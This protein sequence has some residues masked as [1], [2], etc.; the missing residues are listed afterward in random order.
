[1]MK[2][3]LIEVLN[4]SW[5]TLVI[6]LSIVIILRVSYF[7][8]SDKK[9][10]LHEELFSLL[11]FA[12]ILAL[13][14]LVVEQD[15]YFGNGFNLRPFEEIFR[16]EIGSY[17]FYRQ[18]IGNILLFVPFGYFATSY[19]RIKGVGGITI[20]TLLCSSIIETVQYFIGRCFD[21]D[22][23]ILNVVGG[24]IGF[25]VFIAF[26]AIKRRL[27]KFMQKDVFYNIVSVLFIIVIIGYCLSIFG[28]L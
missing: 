3:T 17:N 23:I 5:P 18:V 26:D 1:M 11:F 4:L 9:M 2:E 13:F 14:Q 12:Y 27:P 10:V 6:V 28:V 25:L 7:M 19:A 20:I 16:Y 15:V 22:D 21:I 24:I 8:K